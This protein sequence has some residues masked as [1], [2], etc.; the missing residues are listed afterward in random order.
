MKYTIKFISNWENNTNTP[1]P[2]SA[3]FSD[4]AVTTHSNNVKFFEIGEAASPGVELIAELGDVTIFA[5]EVNDAI[6]AGNA[7]QVLLGPSLFFTTGSNRTITIENVIIN[8]NFPLI[9]LLSMI[10]PSPDWMI[11]VNSLS[12]LDNSGA[13]IPEI[14]MDLFPYDAGTEDGVEYSLNNPASSPI[15]VISNI[16]GMHTFNNQ[17]I[18]TLVISSEEN[19]LNIP[20]F[21]IDPEVLIYQNVTKGVT[22]SNFENIDLTTA[23]I[24]SMNGNVV[25][26]VDISQQKTTNNYLNLDHLAS[27]VYILKINTV[28]G[29][30]KAKK[31]IIN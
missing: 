10:A 13:W 11:A 28:N 27:G 31:L 29:V 16:T 2:N 23:E 25:K 14:T 7:N 8:K 17:K 30:S 6:S 3:H 20:E 1:L 26:R 24:Y 21:D 5:N 18:G 12:V 15:G 19:V 9:S 4:L 22:I